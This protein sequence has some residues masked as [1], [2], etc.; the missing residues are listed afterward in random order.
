MNTKTQLEDAIAAHSAHLG[1]DGPV[2]AWVLILTTGSDGGEAP[3]CVEVPDGQ[4][5]FITRGLL[6][7]AT[8]LMRGIIPRAD[9]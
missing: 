5:G 9:S 7:D 1:S 6:G 4:P 3:I 2:L 8:D